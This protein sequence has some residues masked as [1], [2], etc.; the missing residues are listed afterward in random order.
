MRLGLRTII[1]A[2][3][4]FDYVLQVRRKLDRSRPSAIFAI[5]MFV[6]FQLDAKRLVHG[7]NGPGENDRPACRA[8]L[9]YHE[10]VFAGE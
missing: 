2:E 10:T 5:W 7:S 6:L 8:L 1:Q 9:F 4:A 3:D